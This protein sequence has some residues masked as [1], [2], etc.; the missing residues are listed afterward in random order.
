MYIM[1]PYIKCPTL[2]DVK[3]LNIYYLNAILKLT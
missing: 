3:T 2:L 1:Q